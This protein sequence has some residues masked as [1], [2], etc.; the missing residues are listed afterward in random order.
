MINE[1]SQLENDGPNSSAGKTAGW[2]ACRFYPRDAL[3]VRSLLRQCVRLSQP[4]LYRNG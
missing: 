2:I 4:V 1:S 3:L